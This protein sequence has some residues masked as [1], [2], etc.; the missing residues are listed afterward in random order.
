MPDAPASIAPSHHVP[1]PLSKV[2]FF[3]VLFRGSLEMFGFVSYVTTSVAESIGLLALSWRVVG[4]YPSPAQRR[5]SFHPGG[6]KVSFY[7]LSEK[8]P[9]CG[10]KTARSA[11]HQYLLVLNEQIIIKV[12]NKLSFGNNICMCPKHE[13]KRPESK[14]NDYVYF[15]K[16][17][18][19]IHVLLFFK[20]KNLT[21]VSHS[22]QVI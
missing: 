1:L 5:W 8:Y 19:L 12:K 2:A 17:K 7:M 11:C 10:G 9:T 22:L 13:R 4:S 21:N 15:Q 6:N 18:L 14:T 20:K 16:K 3:R